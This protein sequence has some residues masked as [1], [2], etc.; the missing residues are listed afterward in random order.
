VH[1][2]GPVGDPNDGPFDVDQERIEEALEWAARRFGGFEQTRP[3]HTCLYTRTPDHDFVIDRIG[4]IVIGSACSGHGFK[5]GP[6]VGELLADLAL[7]TKPA[8]DI[9]DFS[10]RRWPD[11]R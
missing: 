1:L 6:L 9:A 5:F 10:S 7:G 3:P 8:V 11:P 2:S 4:S